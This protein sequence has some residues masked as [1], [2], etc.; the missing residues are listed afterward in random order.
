M[1]FNDPPADFETEEP[2]IVVTLDR[3]CRKQQVGEGWF[4]SIENVPTNAIS[5]SIRQI[6]KSSSIICTVP[7]RRKAEALKKTVEGEVSNMVPA[8]ILQWHKDCHIF[9]DEEAGSLL[10]K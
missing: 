1:A 8:S 4:S 7:D 2:F 5:M 3:D 6:R 9:T 10:E